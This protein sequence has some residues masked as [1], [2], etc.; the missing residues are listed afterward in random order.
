[1]PSVKNPNKPSK[2]RLA[3]R[4]AKSK[5]VRAQQSAA[6]KQ[7]RIEKADARRGARPGLLPTSGPNA[8][9]SSKKQRKREKQLAHALKRKM[10]AEG[11]VVMKDAPAADNKKTGKKGEGAQEDEEGMEID[12]S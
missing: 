8:P 10:E 3:A 5:K 12:I 4:A 6:G 9:L 11:E 2:N 7:S 1:M